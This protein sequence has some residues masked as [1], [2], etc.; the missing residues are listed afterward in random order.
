MLVI[1]LENYVAVPEIEDNATAI[2]WILQ[3]ETTKYGRY[4]FV[5][6]F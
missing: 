4:D 5:R 2:Y 6:I 3:P 1:R